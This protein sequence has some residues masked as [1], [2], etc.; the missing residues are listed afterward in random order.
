MDFV[1]KMLESG[2][3]ELVHRREASRLALQRAGEEALRKL[4]DLRREA[5]PPSLEDGP[6]GPLASRFGG[7]PWLPE[8]S[9]WPACGACGRP[10]NFLVQLDLGTLPPGAAPL[11]RGLFQAFYCVACEGRASGWE[12]GSP[13]HVLRILPPG[14]GAVASPPG[15]LK[16]F[17]PRQVVSWEV[18]ADYPCGGDLSEEDLEAVAELGYPLAGDKLGG[19]PATTQDPP[20]VRCRTCRAKC[21]HFL[22]IDSEGAL[23]YMWGDA[24]IAHVMRC[25]EHPQELVLFW[26]CC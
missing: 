24:G 21:A 11:E 8:G 20:V 1:R 3:L 6:G 16:I 13:A 17:P 19:W 18:Q 14:P 5:W 4:S 10:A 15:N 7:A 2:K 12:P 9:L 26:D 22:Q 23:A 25:P